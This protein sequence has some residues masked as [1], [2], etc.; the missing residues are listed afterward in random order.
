MSLPL[1]ST[2]WYIPPAR[3]G[4]I[5]RPRLV[6]RLLAGVKKPAGLT[7]L[8]ASAGYGKTTLLTEF[9]AALGQPVA[10]VSLDET[11]ND[12]AR[13]W[14]YLIGAC[15]TVQIGLGEAA[16]DLFPLAQPLPP[17]TIPTILIN[18]LAQRE[19]LLVL[20]LDDYH[21][22]RDQAIHASTAFLLD[23]QPRNLHVILSTRI[24]PPWPL[25]RWRALG[26]LVEI[27]SRDLRFNIEETG[28]FLS[29]FTGQ[30][31]PAEDVEALQARTEG[32]AAGLQLAAIA[33]QSMI[34]EHGPGGI[35]GFIKAF[36]GS[37][38]YVA[39]YLL[40][41][42]LSLQPEPLQGFLLRTSILERFNAE[43]C[44]AVSGQE[45]VQELLLTLQRANLFVISLDNEGLW[46]R[47][48][49]IF[50]DLL[51]ARLHQTLPAVE[52][53]GLHQRAADWYERNGFAS[54]SINHTLAARDFERAAA[55]VDRII[56]AM[57][58]TGQ[59]NLL[60]HW[61]GAIPEEVLKAYPRLE[62][63]RILIDLSQG[64][65][66]MSE[67][68][69]REKETLLRSLPP[70]PENDR[71]RVEG[72]L[73]LSLFL[74]HQNTSRAIQLAQEA[75]E[76]VPQTDFFSRISLF[77]VL[78]RAYGMEGDIDKSEPAYLECLRLTQASGNYG[79]ASNTTMVRAFDLCQYGRLDEAARYCQLIIQAVSGMEGKHLYQAGPAYIG[80]AGIYLERHDLEMAAETLR[81]GLDLCRQMG[82]DG[83]YIGYIAQARLLQAQGD[84]NAAKEG[85][86]LVEQT[87][88]RKDFN[89][90][91]RQ[92]S[93][94]LALGDVAGAS[95]LLSSLL[96]L[97]NDRSY[98]QRLPLIAVEA[99]KLSIARIYLAQGEIDRVNQLLDEIQST[100]EPGQ[101][102]G[103]LV[104]VH[105]LRALAFHKQA[106]GH[107]SSR[108]LACLQQALDLAEPASI[109]LLI[110]EEGPALVPLLQAFL[111]Y[112]AAPV[113]LKKY[114]RKLLGISAE[115]LKPEVS[116][117]PGESSGLVEPLTP[118]EMEVLALIAAGD[119]NQM[120]ADK[121]VISVRTVKKHTGN[122]YGKLGAANRLQAVTR[123]R[124]LGLLLSD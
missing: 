64:T 60:N 115:I 8:S 122:I 38:V 48:H 52:I 10:W 75:L 56:R 42:V 43:L 109:V 22:I 108:A 32:W 85:L 71:T 59:G 13:F 63:Y 124:Q 101:R 100:V 40:D 2:K 80:L 121:L 113:H 114:A 90:V 103:R 123:A 3:E 51:Q 17:E 24:D 26:R 12:L 91:A 7:L 105:L 19:G 99:F 41:E 11:D 45:G 98:A 44:R 53:N 84:F 116:L 74:A 104:E 21:A 94:Q 57:L 46:F 68:T 14:S 9:I 70:S 65:L 30:D 82:Q 112:Q 117:L 37:H 15:Q 5:S 69:L 35:G 47:Y 79:I 55:S 36:T 34:S 88:R 78:Y 62:I 28:L 77:S 96:D 31:L 102:F 33:L 50:M 107:N 66:D 72:M 1:L 95:A 110:L 92:V 76:E 119:S 111:H 81:R 106:T 27:R 18:D 83:L 39:E 97:L 29:R 49:H 86:R 118:R 16:L 4:A 61:L 20:V 120:I 6:E 87:F 67:Q 23:H 73:Y 25:A 89:L 54:E 93:L 58:Y